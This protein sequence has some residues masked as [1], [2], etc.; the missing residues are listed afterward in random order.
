MSRK[1]L[2]LLLLTFLLYTA[3]FTQPLVKAG[4]VFNPF[5]AEMM[6]QVKSETLYAYTG[7]LSG[8][9]PVYVNGEPYRITTRATA[10]GLPIQNAT[11]YVYEH[12]ES[13]GLAVS[14]HNW[15][16]KGYTGRN[17]AGQL[18]G[19]SHPD[20]IVLL[21]AHLDDYP[22]TGL[23]PGA[24]DNA[25]GSAG[26]LLAADILSQ[27]RFDRSL[28]FVF[29]TGEEQ[30]LYGSRQYAAE[31]AAAGEYIQ[32]VLNL[33]MIAWDRRDAP[34]L[35]L[36]TRSV[37]N[38]GYPADLELALTFA[39]VIYDYGLDGSL[40]PVI[41]PGGASNSD[42]ASFWD[43]GYPAILA[44]EDNEDDFNRF[45]HSFNDRLSELNL[46]YFSSF[47]EA[48]VGTVAGLAQPQSRVA[49]DYAARLEPPASMQWGKPG[50]VAAYSLGLTNTGS[51][52]DTYTFAL[53]QSDWTT[54][55]PGIVGPLA[56][57]ASTNV[58]VTVAI[59]MG[60]AG[61]AFDRP[62]IS[63]ISANTGATLDGTTLTTVVVWKK[64]YLPVIGR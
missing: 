33:D 35:R 55:L 8:E 31:A 51:M 9:W 21:T 29:F 2:G 6:A 30:G 42:H 10:S 44:I 14:Y 54:T 60:A 16:V 4:S 36:H 61:G 56:A 13:L 24:D 50:K 63:I 47:V 45:Y 43:V 26:V 7:D 22:S 40:V 12:L 19:I 34:V 11:Q 1:R 37:Y 59:P 46:A 38:A 41:V 52:P 62:T 57:D 20:E 25:S 48:A 23:A 17:V 18:T 27:Y 58:T 39:N 15:A 64:I 28:R 49:A 3:G 53:A 5:V 32:A